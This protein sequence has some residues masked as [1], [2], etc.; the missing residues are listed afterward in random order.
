MGR[1]AVIDLPDTDESE[2][3]VASALRS[4]GFTFKA[5][6]DRRIFTR[7]ASAY[8]WS[9]LTHGSILVILAFSIL[10]SAAGFIATQRVYV[11]DSITTAFDWKAGADR[12]LP[13]EVRADDF[14]LMPN[15]V[16]VRLGVLHVATQR[17]G[18]AITTH[19]GSTFAV[20]G[21]RG[22]VRLE[23]F[24]VERKDFLAT[25]TAADGSRVE[26]GKDQEI[27]DT[28]ISLVPVAFATWPERQ[29]V[30]GVTLVSGDAVELPAEISVNHPMVTDGVRI[31][32]TDYGKDRFGL[33]YVGFQFVRDPG[34]A[35]V[36]AG[37]I[38]FLVCLPGTVWLR[39]SCAVIVRDEGRLKVHVSSRGNRDEI[40]EKLREKMFSGT[41]R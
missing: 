4:L 14:T 31:Y 23:S 1:E 3:R 21:V 37:C 36:W 17:R 9:L 15:P 2:M 34:Q 28:G 6:G 40:I 19:E 8:A 35:G 16:G 22:R 20:P 25:W 32:L 11:G 39:H 30:A 12:A 18:K 24:D 38:L 7:G 41:G 33:P 5:R 13:F 29:A 27:G 10:G 26:F